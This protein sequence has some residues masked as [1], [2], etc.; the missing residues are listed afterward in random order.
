[1]LRPG[2]FDAL[3]V[4]PSDT[5]KLVRPCQGSVAQDNTNPNFIGAG[6]TL[7]PKP[8]TNV[9]TKITVAVAGNVALVDYLGNTQVFTFSPQQGEIN[10]RYSQVKATGTTATGITAFFPVYE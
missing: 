2:I 6:A 7:N 9:A 4:A 10:I 1:M 5:N 3:P 8:E